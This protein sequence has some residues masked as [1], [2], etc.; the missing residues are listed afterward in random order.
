MLWSHRAL[1]LTGCARRIV[2]QDPVL[3]SG[4]VRSNLDPFGR[5]SNDQLW[6]ALELVHLRERVM[7]ADGGLD[8]VVTES[9]SIIACAFAVVT[10]EGR[11]DRFNVVAY[12]ICAS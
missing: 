3:F 6:R 4:T 7:A 12:A 8:S 11:S 1:L 9:T 10:A 5:H 2:P